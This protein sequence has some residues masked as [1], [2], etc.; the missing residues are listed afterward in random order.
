MAEECATV[1]V[2]PWG[3]G[4]GDFVEINAEDFDPKQHKLYE[5]KPGK[6]AKSVPVEEP[7]VVEEPAPAEEPVVDPNA[8]WGNS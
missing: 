7:V 8:G 6:A 4:Q 2:K 5:E 3:K 1:K